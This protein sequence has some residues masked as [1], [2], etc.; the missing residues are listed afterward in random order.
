MSEAVAL[1]WLLESTNCKE[2]TLRPAKRLGIEDGGKGK[3]K[4]G[5]TL[6]IL[7]DW[8]NRVRYKAYW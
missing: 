8:K 2:K 3:C 6:S 4:D 7:E 1:D 5:C